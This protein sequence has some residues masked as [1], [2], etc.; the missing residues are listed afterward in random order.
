MDIAIKDMYVCIY[1]YI[2]VLSHRHTHT[3][4]HIYMHE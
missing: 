3:H 4:T 2:K 1:E